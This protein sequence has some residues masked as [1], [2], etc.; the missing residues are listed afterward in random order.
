M[1]KRTFQ[2]TKAVRSAVPLLVGLSGCSGSGKTLSALRIASGIQRVTDG[3]I[4]V[5]DTEARRAAHYADDFDF[6]HVEFKAPFGPLDYL[7]AIE[8][9]VSRGAKVIVIDSM[10]HE[11]EGPGGVLEMHAEEVEKRG[12]KVKMLAWVKPKQERR[13]LLN[14]VVQLGVSL[15]LCFRAK[16]K[17]RPVMGK[18]PIQ[19]GWMPIA[20]EEFVYEMTVSILLPPAGRGVPDWNPAN[21][22]EK[23][24]L[25]IPRQFSWLMEQRGPLDEDAGE[26]M[27]MWAAGDT[28]GDDEL[29]AEI[30]AAASKEDLK[31]LAPKLSAGRDLPR[32]RKSYG[33]R[34]NTLEATR[35]REP[36]EDDEDHTDSGPPDDWE[37]GR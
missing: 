34:L 21:V 3:E 15:V 10:S 31:A 16:E 6:R 32:L 20:G 2:D 22:G 9:C 11:H 8:H 28:D 35:D 36:G 27:A 5:I 29:L 30:R 19:L 33:D 4:F 12:D 17:I 23:M 14:T 25:K 18:D 7:A 24:M 26:R 13:R 1:T 37:P